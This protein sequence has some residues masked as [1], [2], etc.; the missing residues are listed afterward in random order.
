MERPPPEELTGR[1]DEGLS[2]LE[3]LWRAEEPLTFEGAHYRTAGAICRPKPTRRPRPPLWLGEARDDAWCDLVAARADGWNSAPA[4]PARLAEKLERVRAACRRRGRDPSEL[5]I[6]LEIQVLVAPTERRV[7]EIAREIADLP[8]SP[9]VRAR[10]ELVEYVRSN[11][12]RPMHAVVDDWLVGTPDDVAAQVR[13]YQALGVSH[14]MLWFLDFPSRAGM[15]LFAGEVM[16][17]LRR[18]ASQGVK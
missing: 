11:E 17:E 6:S 16:P 7:R 13:A 4:S 9:R 2:L 14:F 3:A 18:S 12:G 8:P 1:V 15:R 5:E 10:P